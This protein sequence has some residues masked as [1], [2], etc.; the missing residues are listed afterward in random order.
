ME[1]TTWQRMP[2]WQRITEAK[3][4]SLTVGECEIERHTSKD[5]G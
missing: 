4:E 5:F 2:A 1:K 3:S